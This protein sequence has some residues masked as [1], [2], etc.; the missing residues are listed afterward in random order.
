MDKPSAAASPLARAAAVAHRCAAL[1]AGRDD[2]GRLTPDT[3]SHTDF[4]AT[5]FGWLA[6]AGLLADPLPRGAGRLRPQRA[7]PDGGR[8]S[9]CSSTSGAAACPPGASTRGTSTR[10]RSSNGSARPSNR[11]APPGTSATH[12]RIFGVW[13][14]DEEGP[15]AGLRLV[16]LGGGRYRMEG[17]KIFCSGAGT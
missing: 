13:N 3:A 7:G 2:S 12:G 9:R 15:G 1:S 14:A 10:S 5:E 8:C 16:D 6:D 11:P 4:P 17:R